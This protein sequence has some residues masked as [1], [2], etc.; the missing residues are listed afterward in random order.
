MNTSKK[1]RVISITSNFCF[2]LGGPEA[3]IVRKEQYW[4]NVIIHNHNENKTNTGV[5]NAS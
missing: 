5:Y 1:E 2:I 4:I 3:Q